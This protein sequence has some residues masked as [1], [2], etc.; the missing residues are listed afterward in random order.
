MGR[1]QVIEASELHLKRTLKAEW[2][3]IC[4]E[5]E[6]CL[7]SLNHTKREIGNQIRHLLVEVREL[8]TW[9]EV[10]DVLKTLRQVRKRL[11][12]RGRSFLCEDLKTSLQSLQCAVTRRLS[13]CFQALTLSRLTEGNYRQVV[14]SSKSCVTTIMRDLAFPGTGAVVRFPHH[15]TVHSHLLYWGPPVSE[16][17]LAGRWLALSRDSDRVRIRLLPKIERWAGYICNQPVD[18]TCWQMTRGLRLWINYGV[19]HGGHC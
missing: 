18:D 13:Y 7:Q 10:S 2:L 9:L 17:K 3:R 15:P 12:I 6:I 14:V 4:G 8:S 16:D 11:R 5:F 1:V 19:F